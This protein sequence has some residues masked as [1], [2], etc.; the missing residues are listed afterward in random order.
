[1]GDAEEETQKV[2]HVPT[3]LRGITSVDGGCTCTLL[4][5]DAI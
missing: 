3:A 5:N 4:K 1:M 2:K